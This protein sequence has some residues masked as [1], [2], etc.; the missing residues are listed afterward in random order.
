VNDAFSVCH[1][2]QGSIII[3]PK[4]LKSFIGISI[5]KEIE[6][7]SHFNFKDKKA[8]FFLGGSKLQDYMPI[9][10]NLDN[11]NNRVIASG[12]LANLFLVAKGQNLGYENEWLQ[13]NGFI[14]IIDKIK[15]LLKKYPN[16]IILPLDFAIDKNG[17]REEHM[18]FDFPMD[19]KIWDIGQKSVEMYKQQLTTAD[20][21]FMKGPLG[22]SEVK[23]FSYAT[24]EILKEISFFTKKKKV[25]SLLGGG[26]LTTS[27]GK[28]KI[29]DN[30][31]HISLSGGA[32]IAYI[33]GEKLPGLKALDK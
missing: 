26:H 7:L 24:V 16:Q 27:I 28:Y 8:I 3:P 22:Y 19:A 25:F 13:K 23:N 31:S 1:R 14:E 10:N 12:V 5:E 9:F 21:V 4:Y 6:A 11:K 2:K 32:L 20:A 17:K 30:F 33:S 29:Q 18:I 15:E